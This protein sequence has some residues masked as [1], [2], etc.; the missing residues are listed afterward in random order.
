M[1]ANSNLSN[2][3][4][5]RD[6]LPSPAQTWAD[7]HQSHRKGELYIESEIA[8]S[9]GYCLIGQLAKFV[10]L[11]LGTVSAYSSEFLYAVRTK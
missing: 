5:R 1:A 11:F 9:R 8:R 3:N 2:K 4:A 7:T 6:W 10:G